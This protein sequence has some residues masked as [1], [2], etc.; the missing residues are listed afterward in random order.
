MAVHAPHLYSA[1][2][3]M[4]DENDKA[5]RSLLFFCSFGVPKLQNFD[6]QIILFQQSGLHLF[7]GTYLI[8]QLQYQPQDKTGLAITYLKPCNITCRIELDFRPGTA[9]NVVKCNWKL[10][11]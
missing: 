8:F 5:R 9:W 6:V 11:R 4:L 3:I 1:P 2:K 7:F 10:D